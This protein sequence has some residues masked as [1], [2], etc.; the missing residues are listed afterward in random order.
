MAS[1]SKLGLLEK[2][3]EITKEYARSENKLQSV[4]SVL[5]HVYEKLKQLNEDLKSE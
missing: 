5:E 2:A 3:I 4:E 1:M